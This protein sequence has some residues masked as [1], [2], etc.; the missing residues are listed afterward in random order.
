MIHA[1]LYAALDEV[2]NRQLTSW[3]GVGRSLV[4]VLTIFAAG[5]QLRPGA[6]HIGRAIGLAVG[7][8]I[9]LGLLLAAGWISTETQDTVQNGGTG[10]QTPATAPAAGGGVGQ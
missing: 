7:G 10:G 4:V 8:A 5:W 1:Y 9:V 3:Q 2:A 6:A